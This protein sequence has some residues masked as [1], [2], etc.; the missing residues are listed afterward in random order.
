M[1]DTRVAVPP[2]C[3]QHYSDLIHHVLGLTE[4]GPWQA[5]S[6]ACNLLLAQAVLADDRVHARSEGRISNLSLVLAE[7]GPPC[8]AVQPSVLSSVYAVMR[9]GLQHASRVAQGKQ[10]DPELDW[11]QLTHT[12]R[13]RASL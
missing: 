4:D 6:V 1:T 12:L 9:K 8:C 2:L 11:P 3:A 13:E 10:H 7:L 5:A